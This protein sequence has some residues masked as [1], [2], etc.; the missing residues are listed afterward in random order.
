MRRQHPD[1]QHGNEQSGED[2]R[3]QHR[4]PGAEDSGTNSD[5]DT[6]V[7]KNEGTNTATT[8][9]IAGNWSRGPRWWRRHHHV[10]CARLVY[11]SFGSCYS[12]P[13]TL[14]CTSSTT[15]TGE[16]AAA[17]EA[18][19]SRPRQTAIERFIFWT[20]SEKRK[21][22]SRASARLVSWMDQN[23]RPAYQR[24]RPIS[25]IGRRGQPPD[26]LTAFSRDA[27]G[28]V[29][30]GRFLLVVHHGPHCRSV[31]A[32]SARCALDRGARA[33]S[34]RYGFWFHGDAFHGSCHA[35]CRHASGGVLGE[36]GA[37][38][39]GEYADAA[40]ATCGDAVAVSLGSERW[41]RAWRR[42][43]SALSS[44]ATSPAAG[45]HHHADTGAARPHAQLHRHCRLDPA[46][47]RQGRAAGRYCLQLPTS[48][49][50]SIAQ[51]GR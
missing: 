12:A 31:A 50:A 41:S 9:S 1:R 45:F 30:L 15:A 29:I 40:A 48:S 51:A 5:C 7:M 4:E 20:P 2:E 21:F 34:K 10:F 32:E 43:S 33:G 19:A 16:S 25:P 26:A 49:T 22:I 44:R 6:P 47:R 17:G 35:S 24:N 42:R 28:I 8:D 13:V 14:P 23:T 38:G 3:S 39:G 36:R 11:S 27:V 46:V 18:S 37:G